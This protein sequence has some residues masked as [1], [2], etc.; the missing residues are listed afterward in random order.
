MYIEYI[1]TQ[2]RRRKFKIKTLVNA[3]QR[4]PDISVSYPLVVRSSGA[5]V[6]LSRCI[7]KW[8]PSCSSSSNSVRISARMWHM[9]CWPKGEDEDD[10]VEALHDK[11]IGPSCSGMEF[12]GLM[13]ADGLLRKSEGGG[14][15]RW[16]GWR[17]CRAIRG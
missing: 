6:S 13:E 17:C 8:P 12:T 9:D 5:P 1:Q 2:K 3:V 11:S 7:T 15:D 14:G 4:A 10:D 16:Y